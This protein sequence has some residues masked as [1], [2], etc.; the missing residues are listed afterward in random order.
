MWRGPAIVLEKLTPT[1]YLL[2]EEATKRKVARTIVNIWP[3]HARQGLQLL[4]EVKEETEYER[5]EIVALLEEEQ[6]KKY[7][8]AKITSV[9]EDTMVVRYLGTTQKDLRKA[10]F[11][12]ASTIA[13]GPDKNKVLLGD[14]RGKRAQ[15]FTG[16]IARA[17][18]EA[19][20]KARHLKQLMDGRFSAESIKRLKA[21]KGLK[22]SFLGKASG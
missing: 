8:I 19:L 16:M 18:L 15:P 21:M 12:P 14:T 1:A 10:Q 13:S 9:D 20:I 11:Q 17:D 3:Y 4:S 2:E 6:C 7:D 22:H 5:G